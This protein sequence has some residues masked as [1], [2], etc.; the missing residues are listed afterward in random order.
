MIRGQKLS[1][2]APASLTCEKARVALKTLRAHIRTNSK[3]QYLLPPLWQEEDVIQALQSSFGEKC[4][5]CE[6]ALTRVI[7][8]H[9]RPKTHYPSLAYQW[10][11]LLP[12]CQECSAAKADHFPLLSGFKAQDP[13]LTG[14]TASGDLEKE[15][16]GLLNP[17][18]NTPEDLLGYDLDGRILATGGDLSAMVTIELLDLNRPS[19]KAARASLMEEIER[20]FQQCLEEYRDWGGLKGAQKA[21][22]IWNEKAAAYFAQ[23]V[24][25]ASPK[26][27][28]AGLYH[29]SL[30][31][32]QHL[33]S[34][35]WPKQWQQ[36]LL[37][38]I[39]EYLP[40]AYRLAGKTT[41]LA[42]I[43]LMEMSF[44]NVRCFKDVHV[45]A[46]GNSSLLLGIN[47]RGKS[48]LLQFPA[49]ALSGLEKSPEP[50]WSRVKKVGAE[51]AAFSLV[52]RYN[53]R[54]IRLSFVL[55]ELDRLVPEE[56]H[57]FHRYI[58]G[59]LLV[60][61][62]GAGRQ[63][64]RSDVQENTR[65]DKVASLFGSQGYLKNIKDSHVYQAVLQREPW[66]KE[67]I[68]KI[69][70]LCDVRGAV[71]LE[72][73]DPMSA[74]FKTATDPTGNTPLESMSDGFRSTYA[75]VFDLLV[76]VA[77][78]GG[79]PGEPIHGIVFIDEIDLHIHPTWQR[80]LL[81]AMAEIFPHIQFITTSHSLFVVQS[82]ETDNIYLLRNKD[83]GVPAQ[84][85]ELEGQPNGHEIE[86]IIAKTIALECGIP[87]VTDTLF[88]LLTDLDKAVEEADKK[89]VTHLYQTI[90]RMIPS[91]SNYRSYVEAMSAGLLETRP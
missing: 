32:F 6:Q 85:L 21:K 2:R 58:A 54:L 72:R 41:P 13:I 7:V 75:W 83:D 15:Q 31:N 12:A 23:L 39:H 28:F 47:G 36:E 53:G 90:M 50:E 68:N 57:F 79:S 52:L 20:G 73:F 65:Y 24:D 86:S 40:Q 67:K 34:Q 27:P 78:K 22:D 42:K 46:G 81:P 4:A 48:T 11:N 66:F 33:F 55:D 63:V 16:P 87:S 14:E 70:A 45:F 61:G 84:K 74:W 44:E 5:Y 17:R 8:D 38:Q 71:V 80:L 10:D 37:N 51:K 25:K 18:T 26:E 19:L 62:Y 35:A 1:G 43:E 64:K 56:D 91:D 60:L 77:E 9:F 82:M 69:L 29:Y 49:L 59:R 88:D 30:K 76:R 89:R 3:A